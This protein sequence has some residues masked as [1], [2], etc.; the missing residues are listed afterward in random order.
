[1]ISS[2]RFRQVVQYT[3]AV[4]EMKRLF[5]KWQVE[6][7]SLKQTIAVGDGAND[8]PMISIAGLGVAFHAKSIVEENAQRSISSVGLDGLLYLMGISEREIRQ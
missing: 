3:Y 4:N 5:P 7:I 2:F 8:L 6:N 1:M